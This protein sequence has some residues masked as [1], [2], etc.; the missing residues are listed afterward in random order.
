M[1]KFTTLLAV[2]IIALVAMVAQAKTITVTINSSIGVESVLN[3]TNSEKLEFNSDGVAE[4]VEIGDN[5]SFYINV[6]TRDGWNISE[7]TVNGSPITII[8]PVDFSLIP[9]GGTLAIY[10]EKEKAKTVTFTVN[11]PQSVSLFNSSNYSYVYF[12]ETGSI[13]LELNPNASISINPSYNYQIESITING[14]PFYGTYIDASLVTD[15]TIVAITTKEKEAT[16][17]YVEGNPDQVS[18]SV[19]YSSTYDKSNFIDGK[20]IISTTNQYAYMSISTAEGYVLTSIVKVVPDG[21]DEE[22]LPSYQKYQ[23]SASIGLGGFATGTTL[24]ITCATLVSLRTAHCSVEVMPTEGVEV[25]SPIR[26]M[27]GNYDVPADEYGDIAYIPEGETIS[28][29]SVNGGSLYKVTVDGVEQAVPMSGNTYT[30][31]TLPENALIKVWPD[32]PNVTVPVV[33]TYTNEGTEGAVKSVYVDNMPVSAEE[34]QAEGWSVKLGS[35]L[36]VNFNYEEYTISSVT[37]NGASASTYSYTATVSSEDP[38]N[39]TVTATKIKG[40]DVTIVY[41]PGTIEVY[42]DYGKSDPIELPE[43][44]DEVTVEVMPYGYLYFYAS[45]GYI[46]DEIEDGN[47]TKYPYGYIYVTEDMEIIVTAD[48]F[49]RD[50]NVVVYLEEDVQWNYAT[51]TL[52]PF[53]S[54]LTKYVEI[55][56]GYN[57][58]EY[59]VQDAPF[60]FGSYPYT[61][62]YL[63]G[64]KIENENGSLAATA[65]LPDN[66]VIK[67]FADNTQVENYTLNISVDS[68]VSVDILA[69]YVT[70]IEGPT[71]TVFGPT[72]VE[73]VPVTRAAA[74]PFIVKVNGTEIVPTEEGRV[75]ASITS[76]AE[77]AVEPNPASSITEINADN[78]DSAIY[79]LQGVRVSN[80]TKG[81]FIKNGKKVIL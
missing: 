75:I 80:P 69:D 14:T 81:I 64:E 2:A 68:S 65:D 62:I 44:A 12:D 9:D 27:R 31:Y 34:W 66:S 67:I 3:T 37:V 48:K 45:E 41:E 50:R 15:G 51:L 56:S 58:V 20:W 28:I 61:N 24:R 4:N 33:F 25:T 73:F 17:V 46:I 30:L 13:T 35:Q 54:S 21:E 18:F 77:I 52:S 53:N 36:S 47:G 70:P 43:G 23:G 42:R 11:N 55:L 76:D 32:F 38:I 60:A 19:D 5:G 59:A 16:V 71:A 79:N 29:S 10:V 7:L 6:N 39:I 78:N 74:L 40:F 49:E 26:V 57:F 1:K 72:D 63:N 8:N 22:L